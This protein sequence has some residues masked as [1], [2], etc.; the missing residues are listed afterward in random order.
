MVLIITVS[1]IVTPEPYAIHEDELDESFLLEEEFSAEDNSYILQTDDHYELYVDGAFVCDFNE[2]PD[3]FKEYPV[4]TE[5]PE[6]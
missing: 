3:E 1:F 4:Y 2:I 6:E 5:K